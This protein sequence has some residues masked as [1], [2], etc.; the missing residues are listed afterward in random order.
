MD[1]V[2]TAQVL[3][4]VAPIWHVKSETARKVRQRISAVMRWAIAQGYREDNPADERV[5]AALGRNTRPPTHHNALHHSQV[6]NAMG[7]IETS[8]VYWAAQA[9][10]RFLIL[11]AARSGEVSVPVVGGGLL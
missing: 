7:V 8:G 5:T 6:K 3:A 9:A 11:T 4:V 10:L 2:T 1:E